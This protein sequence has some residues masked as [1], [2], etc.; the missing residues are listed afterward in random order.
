VRAFK[1]ITFAGALALGT[2]EMWSLRKQWT[3]YDRFY[4]EPTE[5]QKTLLRDAMMF[6]E[7]TYQASSIDEKLLK[8]EDP[9]V[10]L[11]YS[12]MYQLPP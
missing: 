7:R 9:E 5:L 12:Q 10:R 3:Y 8:V 6:K 11:I 1:T 4:P 2:Y